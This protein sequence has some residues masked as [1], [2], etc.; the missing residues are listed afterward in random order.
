MQQYD[1]ILKVLAVVKNDDA[2]LERL[3]VLK[4]EQMELSYAK[5]IATTVQDAEKYK[6]TARQEADW[7]LSEAKKEAEKIKQEA[8]QYVD[9]KRDELT[10]QK[11][12]NQKSKELQV[13][14]EA[15]LNEL[16]AQQQELAKQ[17]QD[18]SDAQNRLSHE[19]KSAR[20]IRDKYES[21]FRQI[22][23]IINS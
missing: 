2:Y 23:Q 20:E 21:K 6:I 11:L 5:E 12:I 17:K 7:F 16:H 9:K 1:D 19:T 14:Y 22:Q 10:R 15:K 4:R 18:L 3:E 13:E 8:S